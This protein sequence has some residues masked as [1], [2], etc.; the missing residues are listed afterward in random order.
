MYFETIGVL[1]AAVLLIVGIVLA[2]ITARKC[3]RR[4]TK[5]PDSLVASII[6]ACG[7]TFLIGIGLVIDLFAYLPPRSGKVIV[8]SVEPKITIIHWENTM[9]NPSI[10]TYAAAINNQDV[11]IPPGG[12]KNGQTLVWND[13]KYH[14]VPQ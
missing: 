8:V 6:A 12:L 5:L 9:A 1:L 14:V 11:E 2:S 3:A 7:V 4:V 10:G 13:G